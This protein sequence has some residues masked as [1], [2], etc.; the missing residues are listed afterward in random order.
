[1]SEVIGFGGFARISKTEENPEIVK[2]ELLLDYID[3]N[4]ARARLK[5][6]IESL[7]LFESNRIV[8]ILDFDNEYFSWYTMPYYKS[9]LE[10]FYN[11]VDVN[12]KTIIK[13]AANTIK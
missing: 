9:N 6:E 2:K 12:E 7:L 8:K 13:I 11:K 4:Q 3:N 10:V 5:R 1:M